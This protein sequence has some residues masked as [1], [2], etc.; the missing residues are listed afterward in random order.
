MEFETLFSWTYL[1]MCLSSIN[2]Q[3]M[4][5]RDMSN[6]AEVCTPKQFIFQVMETSHRNY[7]NI[8]D[9][10]FISI[11]LY[12]Y[13]ELCD[14]CLTGVGKYFIGSTFKSGSLNIIM[15]FYWWKVSVGCVLVKREYVRLKEQT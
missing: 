5:A 2:N 13:K 10:R 12:K 6:I 11:I 9:K 14:D 4:S 1:T 15:S 8:C 3:L 7:E